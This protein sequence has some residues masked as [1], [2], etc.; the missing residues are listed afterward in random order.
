MQAEKA[1]EIVVRPYEP[2]AA[3]RR[4]TRI[5]N[6]FVRPLLRSPVGARIHELALLRFQGLR[7]GK[8]YEVPVEY[9]EL[10]GEPLVLTASGWKRNLRGGADVEL[11]HDGRMIPMHAELIEDEDE[12]ARIY[13]RLLRQ[14]G[15]GGMK[16]TRI[17]LDVRVDRIPTRAEIAPAVR[18]KRAVVRLRPR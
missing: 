4:V 8:H 16:A 12:V 1:P 6:A 7:S 13:E 2:G 3:F 11:V 9:H 17:G 18:G 15:V 14:L 10:D 5:G